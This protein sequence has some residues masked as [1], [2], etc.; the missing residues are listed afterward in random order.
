MW[1]KNEKST[2]NCFHA[3]VVGGRVHCAKRHKF[4]TIDGGLSVVNVIGHKKLFYPCWKCPDLDIDWDK[5]KRLTRRG[6]KGK[7]SP[8]SKRPILK[9]ENARSRSRVLMTEEVKIEGG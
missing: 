9:G 4:M 3:K 2:R 8:P 5:E 6:G 1:A 7:V